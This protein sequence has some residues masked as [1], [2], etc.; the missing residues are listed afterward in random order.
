VALS[1]QTPNSWVI[2]LMCAPMVAAH[3]Y[4]LLHNVYFQ[5]VCCCAV[6]WC[7]VFSWPY[8]FSRGEPVHPDFHTKI[9]LSRCNLSNFLKQ[10]TIEPAQPNF[11]SQ[12]WVE[13][14]QLDVFKRSKLSPDSPPPLFFHVRVEPA[15]PTLP[16]FGFSLEWR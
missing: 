6:L 7:L 4:T 1:L 5:L 9:Q 16:T 13:P 2:L 12:I 15:Q 10:K 8:S 11:V 3:K 14:A